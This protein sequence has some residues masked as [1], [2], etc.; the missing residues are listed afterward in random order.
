MRASS[1]TGEPMSPY[2][3]Q[4]PAE[5]KVVEDAILRELADA[6]RSMRYLLDALGRYGS[7]AIKAAVWHLIDQGKVR[8]EADSRLRRAA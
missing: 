1:G 4:I 3:T 7:A 5:L 8:L 2:A 6:S